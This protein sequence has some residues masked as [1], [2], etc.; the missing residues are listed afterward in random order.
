MSKSSK[1]IG[2]DPKGGKNAGNGRKPAKAGNVL[3]TTADGVRILKPKRKAT[4]FTAKELQTAIASVR[5]TRS[6]R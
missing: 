3:G 6:A 4:H 2:S 1:R 5:A